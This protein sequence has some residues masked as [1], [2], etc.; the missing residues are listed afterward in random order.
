LVIFYKKELF[1]P[2][3]L[4]SMALENAYGK[5]AIEAQDSSLIATS[6]KLSEL[7]GSLEQPSHIFWDNIGLIH[8][9][10]G[11]VVTVS[12]RLVFDSPVLEM[13]DASQRWL[14]GA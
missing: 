11:D 14:G 7:P 2:L 9:T 8:Y 5:E 10:M 4:M 3:A 1:A 12:A 6:Q 13:V